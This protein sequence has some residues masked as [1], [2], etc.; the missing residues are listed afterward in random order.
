M[1]YFLFRH[2]PFDENFRFFASSHIHLGFELG[3]ALIL[4]AVQTQTK[5][6]G[7]LT[8]SLW[9]TSVSFLLGPFWFNPVTFEWG[10]CYEDYVIWDRWMSDNVV[11]S[12]GWD[13][14]RI[15]PVIIYGLDSWVLELNFLNCIVTTT[16][17]NKQVKSLDIKLSSA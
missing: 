13:M 15:V 1:L 4:F 6:Y 7:G 2:S 11:S 9:L 14:L 5:Q 17:T 3:A 16:L 8:W 10:K 12:S